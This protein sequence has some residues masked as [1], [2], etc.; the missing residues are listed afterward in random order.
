MEINIYPQDPKKDRKRTARCMEGAQAT[1]VGFVVAARHHTIGGTKNGKKRPFCF[2]LPGNCPVPARDEV[3]HEGE[4]QHEKVDSKH[5]HGEESRKTRI[6][7]GDILYAAA[8]TRLRFD[9][10]SDRASKEQ[11]ST[12]AE[13]VGLR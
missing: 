6:G 8:R 13:H 11:G 3:D 9:P 10:T 12:G 5:L 7:G 1:A 4:R 2:F